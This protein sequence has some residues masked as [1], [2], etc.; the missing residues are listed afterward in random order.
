MSRSLF[1]GAFLTIALNAEAWA[2]LVSRWQGEK[3]ANDSV[4]PNHGVIVGTVGYEPGVIGQAFHF[5][6]AGYINIPNPGAGGL[7]SANGFTFAA[8]VRFDGADPPQ[9][10]GPGAVVSYGR[11]E[12]P[13]GFII[14]QS[15]LVGG[16][17]PVAL[18]INTTGVAN[19]T[20]S[21][22]TPSLPFWNLGQVYHLAATFDAATHTIALYRDG[23]LE[24]S[25]SDV[26]GGAMITDSASLF[27]I[28]ADVVSGATM[29]G[30]LDDVR[31]YNTALSAAE[32]A[33][34]VPEPSTLALLATA[35]L[36]TCRRRRRRRIH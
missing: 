6:D 3:N 14:A 8:W 12:A 33:A 13:G 28:G 16:A 4:G 30:M 20:V 26:P 5:P 19:D 32:I 24:A 17:S 18:F 11:S 2:I 29:D 35:T 1:L 34:I 22:S 23:Q 36:C 25:R 7:A 10:G 15:G 27:R 21:V 31:F 9:Q